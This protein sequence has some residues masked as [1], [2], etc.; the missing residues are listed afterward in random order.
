[1]PSKRGVCVCAIFAIFA[2]FS[3]A[4]TLDL[5]KVCLSL[6]CADLAFTLQVHDVGLAVDFALKHVVNVG[7]LTIAHITSE[8][9][10]VEAPALGRFCTGPF[11]GVVARTA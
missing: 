7:Q 9:C 6:L 4:G 5:T 3:R 1:M 8:A 2:C 10:R 11:D